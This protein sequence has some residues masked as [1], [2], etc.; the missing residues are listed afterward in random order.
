MGFCHPFSGRNKKA[1]QGGEPDEKPPAARSLPDACTDAQ[2][3]DRVTVFRMVERQAWPA[4]QLV[5]DA[6][7]DELARGLE[8]LL[9]EV[10][11]H[12]DVGVFDRLLRQG[13]QLPP[14]VVALHIE[15]ELAERRAEREVERLLHRGEGQV[16]VD[17]LLDRRVEVGVR[18]AED[19]AGVDR[20]DAHEGGVGLHVE[21]AEGLGKHVEVLRVAQLDALVSQFLYVELRCDVILVRRETEGVRQAEGRG[22]GGIQAAVFRDTSSC[23]LL[24]KH[25]DRED[26]RVAE[27]IRRAGIEVVDLMTFNAEL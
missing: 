20:R 19:L 10:L 17:L 21:R 24:A 4:V 12:G 13:L 18:G 27:V 16:Q 8:L 7:V 9:V 25:R 23:R 15:G 14:R 2:R 5:V 1:R 22:G 11:V 26:R 3:V 6:H